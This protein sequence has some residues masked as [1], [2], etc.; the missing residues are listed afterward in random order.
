MSNYWF[1]SD[2]HFYHTN[3]IKFC[4]R[5]FKTM[6][7]MNET[8]IRN[9]NER[10]KPGDLVYH[11]GDFALMLRTDEQLDNLVRRL[12]GQI[13]LVRGNHDHKRTRKCKKFASVQDY[14]EIKIGEQRIVL[15]HYA[16]RV[17]NKSHYSSWNLHGHSHGS[18]PR[19]YDQ[20]QLDVGVDC[21]DYRPISFDEVTKEMKKHKSVSVD[22]H[23]RDL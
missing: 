18:L 11:V 1:I 21:W 2:T 5:P 9:W 14:L 7:E 17:W 23:G 16:F 3:V 10:V 15:C 8:M 22:H 13:H 20:K 19:N 6:E 12:N 4:N